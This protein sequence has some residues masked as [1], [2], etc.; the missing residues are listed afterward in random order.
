VWRLLA[1]IALFAVVA[2]CGSSQPPPATV[3]PSTQIAIEQGAQSQQLTVEV[4]ANEAQRET[5][6]MWRQSMPNDTGMLFIF[7]EQTQTGFWMKNTYIPLDIAYIS[8]EGEVLGVVHGKPLDTTTLAAPGPY[9]YALEM[10]SGW[11]AGHGL[12]K[13]ATVRFLKKLPAAS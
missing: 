11:F 7:P 6:L 8:A 3:L 13:G 10:N 5:G 1:V 12:G 4:A 2:G 9:R